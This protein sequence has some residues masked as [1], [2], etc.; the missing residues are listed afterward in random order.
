MSC[1]DSLMDTDDWYRISVEILDA[2]IGPVCNG[3]TRWELAE[4]APGCIGTL[5]VGVVALIVMTVASSMGRL[6]PGWALHSR[7]DGT[8]DDLM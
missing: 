1:V 3:D 4:P 5:G 8:Y 2:R 7:C 6:V